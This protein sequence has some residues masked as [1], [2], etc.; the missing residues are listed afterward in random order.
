MATAKIHKIGSYLR[1][2]HP[3]LWLA[4]YHHRTHKNKPLTFE[5]HYYLK[6]IY[7]DQSDDICIMKSTQNGIS[8]FLIVY[9]TS[10]LLQKRAVFYV[11]PTHELMYRFVSN[12]WEKSY[13]Y[14]QFYRALSQQSKHELGKHF[15]T[16]ALKDIGGGVIS[17][18]GS[19]SEVPF[20]E[21]PADVLIID[22]KDSC[23]Q[24][25]IAMGRERLDHSDVRRVITVG[26]PTITRYGIHED[27]LESDQKLWV[28]KCSNCNKHIFPDFFMHIVEEV[29][30][31]V[32]IIRDSERDLNSPDD[33]RPIC[34]HCNKPFDRFVNGEHVPK[35]TDRR[36]SG[37]QISKLYSGTSRLQDL[38]KNFN[39]GLVND[40]KMERFYNA[41]LGV[42]YISKGAKITRD[43]LNSVVSDYNMPSHMKSGVC[44]MGVDVGGVIHVRIDQVLP[45]KTRR[46]VFIGVVHELQDLFD[47][48]ERF[49][50]KAAVIDALPETRLSKSF[51]MTLPYAFRCFF[52]GEKKDSVN[53]KDKVVTVDRTQAFDVVKENYLLKRVSIP[54]NAS[55][56]NGYYDQMMASTRVYDDKRDRYKW[57]EGTADDHYM[58]AEVYMSIAEKILVM[59]S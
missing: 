30:D 6:Q 25:H 55:S 37:Y 24:D 14:S 12:R 10:E 57:D 52:G 50:V 41:D 27:Y 18:A 48:C 59:S 47:L 23:N 11:L 19:Q 20:T 46:A 5:N 58:L 3:K 45:D 43:M 29:E 56:I 54:K 17:F 4:L 22:E 8:E 39:D 28:I 49:P 44:I 15:E 51:S 35:Y 1:Q 31:N 36:K 33:I 40:F 16:K 21:F 32:F 7:L 34:H 26:N 2:M 42:P 9:A 38:I 53:I 13:I